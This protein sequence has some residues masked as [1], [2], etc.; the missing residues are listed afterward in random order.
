MADELDGLALRTR[1][2][3]S[4]LI[5]RPEQYNYYDLNVRLAA[6]S[7]LTGERLD[8]IHDLDPDMWSPAQR[9]AP[10]GGE[11]PD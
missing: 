9:E 4:M 5:L 7:E 10:A 6:V 8:I 1:V 11:A 3:A 2:E